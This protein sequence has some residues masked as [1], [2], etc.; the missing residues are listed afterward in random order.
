MVSQPGELIAVAAQLW[1]AKCGSGDV[2]GER[3]SSHLGSNCQLPP[4]GSASAIRASIDKSGLAIVVRIGADRSPVCA[5]VRVSVEDARSRPGS[6][7]WA[8][9]RTKHGSYTSRICPNYVHIFR[10]SEGDGRL[11]ASQR[12][13]Y[14]VDRESVGPI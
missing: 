7:F 5:A 11:G 1:P 10:T 12:T 2:P 3:K 4:A 14:D 13:R 6:H 9:I 8:D